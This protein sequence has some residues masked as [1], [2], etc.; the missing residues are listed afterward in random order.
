MKLSKCMKLAA[1]FKM[2]HAYSIL[3]VTLPA[4]HKS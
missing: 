3:E 4:I 1:I 2:R